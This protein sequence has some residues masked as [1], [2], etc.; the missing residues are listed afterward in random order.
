M[1]SL[2]GAKVAR[3]TANPQCLAFCCKGL[4]QTRCDPSA[5]AGGFSGAR[6]TAS[7]R[8]APADGRTRPAGPAGWLCQVCGFLPRHLYTARPLSYR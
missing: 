2:V 4:S 8:P 6:D 7:G 1:L 5:G 3:H